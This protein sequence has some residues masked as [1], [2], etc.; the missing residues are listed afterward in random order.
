M[1]DESALSAEV[2]VRASGFGFTVNVTVI[3]LTASGKQYMI[4]YA[5]LSGGELGGA[6]GH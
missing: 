6:G 4:K 1:V 5:L 3:S 2:C